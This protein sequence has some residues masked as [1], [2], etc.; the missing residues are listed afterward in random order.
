MKYAIV[1]DNVVIN[2]IVYNNDGSYNT[3]PGCVLVIILENELV[4]KNYTY[5]DGYFMPSEEIQ[6]ME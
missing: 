4:S 1:K 3:D 2:T 6:D 5:I